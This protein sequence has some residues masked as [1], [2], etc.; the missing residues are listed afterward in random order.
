VKQR[1][2][3]LTAKQKFALQILLALIVLGYATWEG[4]MIKEILW[5]PGTA[6]IWSIRLGLLPFGYSGF[7]GYHQ[8]G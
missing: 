1:N 5:L 3:G 8:R 7:G 4:N 6:H 2:L